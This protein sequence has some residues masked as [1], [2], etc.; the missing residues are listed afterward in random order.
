MMN[1]IWLWTVSLELLIFYSPR[2]LSI[3]LF[4][5]DFNTN[6]PMCYRVLN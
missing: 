5:D 4:P 3:V 1:L 6:C 2:S